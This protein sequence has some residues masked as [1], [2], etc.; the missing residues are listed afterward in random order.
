VLTYKTI[1]QPVSYEIPKIKG[2]KFIGHLFPITS[3]QDAEQQLK[4]I[5]NLHHQATHNCP[6]RRA[7]IHY[8]QDLFGT[9]L[10]DAVHIYSSDDGEPS[11]TAAYPMK[12]TLA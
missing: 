11:G 2:S 1:S 7:G 9:W 6:S 4:Q 12:N 5:Q 3:K 10:V 8:H